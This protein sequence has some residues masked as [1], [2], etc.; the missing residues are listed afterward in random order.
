MRGVVLL[1]LFAGVATPAEPITRLAQLPAI[2]QQKADFYGA[3]AKAGKSIKATW[4]LDN[5]LT[6]SSDS[7]LT[8]TLSNV[9]NPDE[10]KAPD[11]ASDPEFQAA[12]VRIEA[13]SRIE[14]DLKTEKVKIITTVRP[15]NPGK[16]TVPELKFVYY[17]PVASR[18]QTTYAV[19][20][21][22]IVSVA[23]A[24]PP[25]PLDGPPDFFVERASSQ[26]VAVPAWLWWAM[27]A[28][29]TSIAVG[30]VVWHRRQY[31]QATERARILRIRAV[32]VALADLR[33]LPADAPAQSLAVIWQRYL[34]ARYGVR[35]TANTPQ[36]LADELTRL[37][38]P[39]ARA[40]QATEMIEQL[41][42]AQFGPKA[43]SVSPL[44]LK[45]LIEAWEGL[46]A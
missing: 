14:L 37:K 45:R 39:Q 19:S 13:P 1:C 42:A 15:R 4:T 5:S 9:L 7:T 20:I 36:E 22:R 24:A 30:F 35:P 12:F 33:R 16:L 25:V 21:D 6:T 32:R 27:P 11:L 46:P 41:H 44:P 18:F 43:Q 10:M 8:L 26:T 17:L 3:L 38:L 28:V 40:A 2:D 29:L 23:V 31:P 34:V